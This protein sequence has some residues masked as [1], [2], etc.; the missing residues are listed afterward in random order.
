VWLTFSSCEEHARQKFAVLVF[1]KPCTFDVEELK[2]RYAT[3]ERESV[4]HQLRDRL[5]R[6]SVRLVV[7]DVHCTIAHL[8]EINVARDRALRVG[9]TGRKLNGC[10]CSS[11]VMSSSASHI[12]TSMATVTL[13]LMSMNRCKV[14]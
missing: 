9:A 14:S 6:A 8:Q 13:S 10:S 4:N 3:R 7:K 11:A 12:G 2:P 5:V 1:V